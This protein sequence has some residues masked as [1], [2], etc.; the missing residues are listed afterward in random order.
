MDDPQAASRFAD[1]LKEKWRLLA[2][3]PKSGRERPDYRSGIRSF[4][5]GN[6]V[7]FYRIVKG[8]IEVVHVYDGRRNLE[9]LF[10]EEP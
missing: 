6:Y 4:P 1:L 8:G 9:E 5:I 3:F 10:K 2:D 7:I